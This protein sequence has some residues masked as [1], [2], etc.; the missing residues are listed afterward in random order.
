MHCEVIIAD[1]DPVLASPGGYSA[2]KQKSKRP[3][4]QRAEAEADG[5]SR[6]VARMLT[7]DKD[8]CG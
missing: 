1:T 4:L 8:G 3:V 7:P 2:G 6:M 5:D